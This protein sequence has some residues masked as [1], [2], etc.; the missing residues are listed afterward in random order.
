MGDK[1][2]HG[3]KSFHNSPGTRRQ[4]KAC[5]WEGFLIP[6]PKYIKKEM[7]SIIYRQWGEQRR[8]GVMQVKGMGW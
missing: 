1:A 3:E 2:K 6:S 5:V 7:K 4:G 8:D